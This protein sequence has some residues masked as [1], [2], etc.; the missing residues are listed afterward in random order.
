MTW[1]ERNRVHR[2]KKGD[3][4]P[5]YKTVFIEKED[6]EPEEEGHVRCGYTPQEHILLGT[7]VSLED[8][9]HPRFQQMFPAVY[10]SIG[11][12][13]PTE[14][15]AQI[16]PDDAYWVYVQSQYVKQDDRISFNE[17]DPGTVIL[18]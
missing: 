9:D 18:S 11:C 14:D 15:L 12:F 1:K 17:Q 16:Y 10:P 13:E 4:Q 2:L 7:D 3:M 5:F 8:I 6:E